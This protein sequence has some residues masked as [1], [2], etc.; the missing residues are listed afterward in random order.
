M[1]SWFLKFQRSEQCVRELP[2]QLQQS[3]RQLRPLCGLQ[4][5]HISHGLAPAC[6][7]TLSAGTILTLCPAL[8]AWHRLSLSLAFHRCGGEPYSHTSTSYWMCSWPGNMQETQGLRVDT[9]P[10]QLFVRMSCVAAVELH[11]HSHVALPS[12]EPVSGTLLD[13][14]LVQNRMERQDHTTA[15]AVEPSAVVHWHPM[16]PPTRS[17]PC[18]LRS[19]HSITNNGRG[20]HTPSSEQCAHHVA[21]SNLAEC[22]PH[23]LIYVHYCNQNILLQPIR[24]C[25]GLTPERKIS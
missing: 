7:K 24:Q 16:Y 17:L 20:R 15:E 12:A 14:C 25:K 13:E 1:Y 11:V 6:L 22:I 4:L 19:A 18:K 9:V 23:Q 21:N 5:S 10:V 2:H 3:H 8:I